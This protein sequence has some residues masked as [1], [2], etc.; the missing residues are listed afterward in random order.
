MTIR[1]ENHRHVI[2]MEHVLF[3]QRFIHGISGT[4]RIVL[5]TGWIGFR[6]SLFFDTR[7]PVPPKKDHLVDLQ[8]E[9]LFLLCSSLITGFAKET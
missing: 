4:G 2:H 7:G 9:L 8:V 5:A 6:F 1:G 3:G